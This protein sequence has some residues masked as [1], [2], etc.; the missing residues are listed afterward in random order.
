MSLEI[1]SYAHCLTC[2]ANKQT[3]RLEVGLT[4]KGIQIQCPKHGLV[5]HLTPDDL[6]DQLAKGPQCMCCPGGMHRS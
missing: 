1:H 5:W 2:V 6:R 4:R 3:E